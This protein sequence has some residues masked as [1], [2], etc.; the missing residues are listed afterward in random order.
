MCKILLLI[1]I[2]TVIISYVSGHGRLLEPVGRAS[3]WRY[4]SS[5]PRD[6]DDN[7]SFCG[8]FYVSIF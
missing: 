4:D 7:Q 3:R 6:Y 1:I 5:A 8:G 2:L